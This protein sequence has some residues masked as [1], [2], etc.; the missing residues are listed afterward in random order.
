MNIFEKY[1]KEILSLVKKN[2]KKLNINE[3]N[4]FK[5]INL[6]IPPINFK[7]DLSTNIYMILSKFLH[8]LANFK[9]GTCA[10]F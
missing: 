3:F 10:K 9:L 6:E 5:G 8:L 7:S 1:L 2:K 4:D